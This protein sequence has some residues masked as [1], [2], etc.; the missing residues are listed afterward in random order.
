MLLLQSLCDTAGNTPPYVGTV[1][2]LRSLDD[3]SSHSL[4]EK[5]FGW[6]L[7]GSLLTKEDAGEQ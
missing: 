1:F 7:A 3:R 5:N 2:R 4:R 6:R